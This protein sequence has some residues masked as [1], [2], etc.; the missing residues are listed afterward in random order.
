MIDWAISLVPWWAWLAMAVTAVVV[1][2]RFF[3]WQGAL[4][5]AAG[6]LAALSYGKGR[7][8]AL[9]DERARSDRNNLQAAKDRKEIDDEIDQLGSDDIDQRLARWLRDGKN[10]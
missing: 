2:W 7:A 3:G 4:A 1:V 10:R 6:F 9:R 8:E 5:A